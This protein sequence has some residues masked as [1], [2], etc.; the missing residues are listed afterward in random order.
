MSI[1][2]NLKA[3]PIAFDTLAFIRSSHVFVHFLLQY[4]VVGNVHVSHSLLT[5]TPHMPSIQLTRQ[6][7]S[8]DPTNP[9][10]NK[11]IN[12]ATKETKTQVAKYTI[13]TNQAVNIHHS[14]QVHSA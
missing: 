1:Y 12:I 6:S 3:N 7:K 13:E 5:Q 2:A 8:G 14:P 10:R 4:V 9:T 11:S